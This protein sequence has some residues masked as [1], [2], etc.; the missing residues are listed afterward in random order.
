MAKHIFNIYR[1]MKEKGLHGVLVLAMTLTGVFPYGVSG[2]GNSAWAYEPPLP[3]EGGEP[4]NYVEMVL[5]R[6]P[7][8]SP[9]NMTLLAREVSALYGKQERILSEGFKSDLNSYMAPH[10]YAQ[11][12]ANLRTSVGEEKY[13]ELMK[14]QG[15]IFYKLSK[16]YLSETP[17]GP[18]VGIATGIIDFVVDTYDE[19]EKLGEIEKPISSLEERVSALERAAP[20]IFN[21]PNFTFEKMELCNANTQYTLFRECIVDNGLTVYD[22]SEVDEIASNSNGEEA[23]RKVAKLV[24]QEHKE[25]GTLLTNV[26]VNKEL[27][28]EGIDG[29]EEA[30]SR[31][32]QFE[33]ARADLAGTTEK[34]VKNNLEFEKSL[35]EF[36]TT[37]EELA[38]PDE[39]VRVHR[40]IVKATTENQSLD[41]I[42]D[43]LSKEIGGFSSKRLQKAFENFGL[44]LTLKT[45]EWQANVADFAS[46]AN[47][48]INYGRQ[49]SG[50][51]QAMRDAGVRIGQNTIDDINKVLNY[52][53][54]GVAVAAAI[55]NP[56]LAPVAITKVFGLFG[57]RKP[58]T[59]R[60]LIFHREI[61]GRF[62]DVLKN[63]KIIIENQFLMFE[64][65]EN[66]IEI[67][68]HI[69]ELQ[70]STLK[71]LDNL[72]TVTVANHVAL[73]IAAT[74]DLSRCETFQAGLQNYTSDE[75]LTPFEQ[76]NEHFKDYF[77][78]YRMC[79]RGLI[80]FIEYD[81]EELK[82]NEWYFLLKLA[83]IHENGKPVIDTATLN[84]LEDQYS[85]LENY[86]SNGDI[87]KV[88]L[89]NPTDSYVGVVN[90]SLES[91]SQEFLDL[92]EEN[93]L[94][95]VFQANFHKYVAPGLVKR[96]AK[97]QFNLHHYWELVRDPDNQTELNS[98]DEITNRKKEAL[99]P[100][101]LLEK[102]LSILDVTVAQQALLSGDS[103]LEQLVVNFSSNYTESAYDSDDVL[104]NLAIENELDQER[105]THRSVSGNILL[106]NNVVRAYLYEKM[107]KKGLN[108]YSYAYAYL[109]DEPYTISAILDH[110]FE[111]RKW[112]DGGETGWEVHYKYD[113]GDPTTLG[114]DT[115][116]KMP[117]PEE[118]I[119]RKLL[120]SPDQA[121]LVAI[122]DQIR[123]MVVEYQA[124][125][126]L[127]QSEERKS[128]LFS[129]FLAAGSGEK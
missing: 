67:T 80:D 49:I 9:R 81:V 60:A 64:A 63:Q 117:T 65:L 7:G 94:Q 50:A 66:V 82:F 115:Y 16:K 40:A 44:D 97:S 100:L 86:T 105:D 85:F 73:S 89:L 2:I 28:K 41:K 127:G 5:E 45:S 56:W 46:D 38:G 75:S 87:V 11:T 103:V 62:D 96:V 12:S 114:I 110:S 108:D 53:E 34:L 15:K 70:L 92:F 48:V 58:K 116:I 52:A 54:A 61:M 25:N 10:M 59:D 76:L 21:G 39:R 101:T 83:T 121:E 88:L 47:A 91:K 43:D 109:D 42:A 57:K 8:L 23:I 27:A 14:I 106:L 33:Q 20:K 90:K 31:T 4:I 102:T 122:R 107:R 19:I 30:I 112:E 3:E 35:K 51:L 84:N 120:I 69:Q 37:V 72:T 71:I 1:C 125:Q 104:L 79:V 124:L 24:E 118:V 99:R 119:E 6:N 29:F 13:N 123:E 22:E 18:S 113:D 93:G 55:G 129:A 68:Q 32:V 36:L 17:M 78:D 26:V 111:V 126:D 98:F 74:K 128:L 95:S 77:I